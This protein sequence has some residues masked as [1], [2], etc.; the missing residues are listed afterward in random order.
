MLMQSFVRWLEFVGLTTLVGGLA[1]RCLITRPA[2]LSREEVQ[3]FERHL[4]PVEAG[5]IVLLA[6]T[7]TL[8][9]ILRTLVMSGGGLAALP[10]SLPAVLRHTHFGAIWIAR[11]ALV[12]VLGATW[13]L[14]RLGVAATPWSIMA[15]FMGASLVALTTTLSGHAADWGDVTLPTFVDWVH[16]LA[17]SIWIGGLFAYGL[18]LRRSLSAPAMGEVIRGLSSI[19]RTYPKMA[20]GCVAAFLV[21]GLYNTWLQVG[22]ISSLVTTAYGQAL[23]VKLGLV[24]C[25][26][27]IAAINRYYFLTLLGHR[28]SRHDRLVFRTIRRFTSTPPAEEESKGD[29]RIRHQYAQFVRLEWIIVVVALAC[30][31]LLTQL[32]P[33][34]HIRRHEHYERHAVHQPAHGAAAGQAVNAER[35][36]VRSP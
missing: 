31:A 11:M 12:G 19:A 4:R 21:T 34:R 35:G 22:S 5:S 32:I 13:L 2:I 28:T 20:A 10:M 36:E 8:D 9:L 30:S 15:S 29:E 27:M 14:R 7:S 25:V 6:L 17:V 26:L 24:G 33:A 16:L 18:V 23:L 1:F 3:T